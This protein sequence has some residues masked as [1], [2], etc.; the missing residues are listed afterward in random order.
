MGERL[1]E[2]HCNGLQSLA[3]K[4]GLGLVLVQV[5]ILGLTAA[6]KVSY[7][8]SEIDEHAYARLALPGHLIQHGALHYAAVSDRHA[9][10]DIVGEMLEDAMVIGA[11]HNILY[12]LDYIFGPDTPPT[13]IR[14][15]PGIDPDWFSPDRPQAQVFPLNDGDHTSL[16]AIT[17]LFADAFSR[18]HSFVYVK[19]SANKLV[20]NHR[21]IVILV[22]SMT[23]LCLF[24]TSAMILGILRFA[25]LR[26]LQEA[27]HFTTQVAKGAF[28]TRLMVKGRDELSLLEAQMNQMAADLGERTMRLQKAEEAAKQSESRFRD[29]AASS[30]DWYWET[31]T[32]FLYTEVSM[33][34]LALIE[35][36][37]GDPVGRRIDEI[38]L[39]A[40]AEGGWDWLMTRLRARAPFQDFVISWLDGH[41]QRVYARI[42][43]IPALNGYGEFTGYRGTG[44]DI[45]VQRKAQEEQA[46]LQRQLAVSQKMEAVGQMAGGV[47]HEFNN[48]LAGIL[49][50][51]EVAKLSLDDQKKTAEF[52][53]QIDTLGQRA[54]N[55]A[56]QLLMF[57][58]QSA[59]QAQL[60]RIDRAV[61]DLRRLLDTMLDG[62]ID[63]QI[64]H[65]AGEV[66]A[67]VDPSQ[68]SSC[69][70]NLA[71][72]ARDAMEDGGMLQIT[73]GIGQPDRPVE[74]AQSGDDTDN[75]VRITVQDTGTGMDETTMTR[76]FE[77]FFTT[78]EPGKGTGLGLSI[79][80]S[81]VQDS[82][83]VLEV[84]STPGTGTIFTIY[85][86]AQPAVTERPR[87]EEARPVAADGE[88]V[89]VVDDERAI[90]ETCQISLQTQGLSVATAADGGLALKFLEE[91]K[92]PVK[93]LLVDVL[94]PEITGPQ[95]AE[96]V[97]KIS[98]KTHIVFMS[99]YT[100]R[101]TSQIEGFS[102][103]AGFLRKPFKQA[104]MVG[105]VKSLMATEAEPVRI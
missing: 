29:F 7:V 59:T 3:F 20:A 52:I 71:I 27:L 36:R 91:S 44:A 48:C 77:P 51:T 13:S 43:G 14:D 4:I 92:I 42:N 82:G 25:V 16:V 73:T 40:E 86:P 58:H 47:A 1:S 49:N 41:E 90:R 6:Y 81:W 54:A 65:E 94:M 93:V 70:V 33:Q 32:R 100:E 80:Y 85:L 2:K 75:W 11:N 57:S 103:K 50:F 99:G 60:V 63:L 102:A 67:R 34:Y 62:R 74:K 28:D 26:R 72:N 30:A 97:L 53:G 46:Q 66:W 55:V 37:Y 24:V 56:E 95:L 8:N 31:D 23:L 21:E 78:K 38:G 69:L 18:P 5:T 17:P 12:A 15:M 79:V 101:V 64:R 68:F 39:D 98:P 19:V 22:G 104:Q 84:D 87:P 45:T 76:I 96:E 88:M 10:Q 83:G 35:D 89:L 61:D 105:L 9:M